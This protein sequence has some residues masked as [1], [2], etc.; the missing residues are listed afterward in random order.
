MINKMKIMLPRIIGVWCLEFDCWP[1]E[2]PG[3]DKRNEKGCDGCPKSIKIITARKI[4]KN[5]NLSFKPV[6]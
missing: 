2:H 3:C 6:Q 1:E 4:D 5:D